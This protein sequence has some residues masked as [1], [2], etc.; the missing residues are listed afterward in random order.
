MGWID[1]EPIDVDDLVVDPP[2]D[3]ADEFLVIECSAPVHV[4]ER[5]NLFDGFSE[6]RYSVE[7]NQLSLDRVGGPLN[8]HDAYCDGKVGRVD[9]ADHRDKVPR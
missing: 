3:H 1:C 2:R 5:P 4:G 6:L 9:A 8:L 7:A